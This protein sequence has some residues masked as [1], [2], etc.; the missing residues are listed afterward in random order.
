MNANFR[1]SILDGN[2]FQFP[3]LC[4]PHAYYVIMDVGL[5]TQSANVCHKQDFRLNLNHAKFA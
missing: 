3:R 1:N 4:C 5:F 2:T